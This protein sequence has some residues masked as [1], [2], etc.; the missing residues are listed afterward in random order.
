MCLYMMAVATQTNTYTYILPTH[1]VSFMPS[2]L[3]RT[4]LLLAASTNRHPL[5]SKSVLA[6]AFLLSPLD[7]V[8]GPLQYHQPQLAFPNVAYFFKLLL[9]HL[10]WQRKQDTGNIKKSSWTHFR[11]ITSLLAKSGLRILFDSVLSLVAAFSLE[12]NM[13]NGFLV[14]FCFSWVFLVG[15]FCLLFGCVES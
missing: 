7:T 14:C 13:S 5:N 9:S 3:W 10:Q 1:T 8:L 11:Y 4:A 6:F 15:L 12:V 2:P